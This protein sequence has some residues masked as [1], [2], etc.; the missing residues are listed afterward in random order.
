MAAAARGL[1]LLLGLLGPA[2]G[3]DKLSAEED[4]LVRRVAREVSC[5]YCR[6]LTE[7]IWCAAL[8]L[9]PLPLARP[10]S[11]EKPLW[12]R[13]MTVQNVVGERIDT[14]V[15]HESLQWLQGLCRVNSDL[16]GSVSA[17]A[18][19]SLSV[20]LSLSLSL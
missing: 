8:A 11:S 9:P 19:V 14:S 18:S 6:L 13:S 1:V 5:E 7:D 3:A 15:E 4:E 10:H 20:S 16:L 17:S 12:R 2:A